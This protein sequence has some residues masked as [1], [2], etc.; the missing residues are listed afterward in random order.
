MNSLMQWAGRALDGEDRS[1]EPNIALAAGALITLCAF[2]AVALY[3]GQ[4]W[5]AA[6]FGQA[7]GVALGGGGLMSV[8]QGYLTRQYRMPP[9][10]RDGT[11]A[12]KPDNPDGGA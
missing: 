12:A 3:Q 1:V 5:D 10:P 7:M 4:T 11:A 2:Q 9:L 6:S 8:G